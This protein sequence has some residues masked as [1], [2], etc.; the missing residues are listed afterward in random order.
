MANNEQQ[1]FSKAFLAQ[2]NG[3]LV[4]VTNYSS[5]L[6]NG[7]KQKHTLRQAG[8]GITMGVT[9]AEITFD[10]LIGENGFERD[11]VRAIQRGQLVQLRSKVPGGAVLTYNGAYSN[12]QMDMPL[13]DA[14]KGTVTFIGKLEEQR[15]SLVG[16][17]A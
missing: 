6:S 4:L 3:D 1:F 5:K 16:I 8:A 14:V 11:Y 2:G 13:D 12:L 15:A 9:E 7:A 17:A 10:F